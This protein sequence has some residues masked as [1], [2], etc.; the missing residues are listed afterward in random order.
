MGELLRVEDLQIAYGNHQAVKGAGFVLNQGEIAALVGESGS[1][2]TTVV[3]AIDGLL[4]WEASITGGRFYLEGRDLTKLSSGEWGKIHGKEISMIFQNP[5]SS[6]SPLQ[7][8]DKQFVEN[9]RAHKKEPKDS[10]L[11]RA[12]KILEDM[13]FPEPGKILRAYPFELSGGMCQRAAIALAIMNQPRLLLADE[14]T[15]ALDVAAQNMTIQT[16]LELRRQ[17]GTAILL[18]THNI[19]VA[20][21]MADYIGVMYRGRL[22]EWG[23]KEEVLFHP[24]EDYTRRLIQA[25]P[26]LAD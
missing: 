11:K 6:L 18:V 10:I 13:R 23:T 15:S 17:Y 26:H 24:R 22:L 3:R 12:E 4:P 25:I 14:P 7:T 8:L 20:Y 1:G 5:E 9:V 16:L 2:K 19:G 21:K